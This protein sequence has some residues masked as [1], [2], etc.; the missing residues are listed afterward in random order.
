MMK[1]NR[2]LESLPSSLLDMIVEL[3]EGN[4]KPADNSSKRIMLVPTLEQTHAQ[5]NQCGPPFPSPQVTVA[6]ALKVG[7]HA[8]LP[9]DL[10]TASVVAAC[11]V[12]TDRAVSRKY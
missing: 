2:Q 9:L 3:N 11:D 4:Q 8:G 1:S 10:C 6:S 7:R 5:K 12:T